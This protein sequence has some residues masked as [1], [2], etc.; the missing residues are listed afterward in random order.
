MTLNSIW[1]AENCQENFL[2]KYGCWILE[3]PLILQRDICTADRLP[4]VGQCF[5]AAT[6]VALVGRL[7]MSDSVAQ[8]SED[9]LDIH[10][11]SG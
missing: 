1:S 11:S 7:V 2:T 9:R 10:A 4:E 8:D 6:P 3:Q 5:E